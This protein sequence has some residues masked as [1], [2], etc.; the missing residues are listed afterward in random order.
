MGHRTPLYDM[1]VASGAKMVD[2]GGWDMPI[3]YGSQVQE[4]HSVRTA[5]GICDVSHMTVSD[6]KGVAAKAFLAKLLSNDI[7]RLDTPGKAMYTGMLNEQGG[8]IDDLIVYSLHDGYR[9]VTNCATRDKDL[10]WMQKHVAGFDC[11]LEEKAL[12]II[13]VQGPQTF[14]ALIQAL[15]QADSVKQLDAFR[16]R[17]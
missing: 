3:H 14:D 16:I 8:V 11:K 15:P 10:A 9:L 12:A 7:E 6:L 13:A 17:F 4:H 2:F 1:H 5:V